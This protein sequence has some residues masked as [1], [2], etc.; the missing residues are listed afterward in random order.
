MRTPRS[1]SRLI[2]LSAL[3]P[4]RRNAV[5]EEPK[6]GREW[7][8]LYRSTTIIW[9]PFCVA[10]T[11]PIPGAC[12]AAAFDLTGDIPRSSGSFPPRGPHPLAPH[13]RYRD[14]PW[15]WPPIRLQ[16]RR[17]CTFREVRVSKWRPRCDLLARSCANRRSYGWIHRNDRTDRRE[18]PEVVIG[19]EPG[20]YFYVPAI[21]AM[22]STNITLSELLA[23]TSTTH[24][25]VAMLRDGMPGLASAPS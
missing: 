11:M 8:A 1:C 5:S 22:G 3:S 13:P 15:K 6:R 9:E 12:E 21:G 14:G 17:W 16:V 7:N 2:R 24:S 19:N 23:A 20:R 10:V 18:Y 4:V 25:T